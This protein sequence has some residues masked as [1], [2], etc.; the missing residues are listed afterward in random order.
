MYVYMKFG[1][2]AFLIPIHPPNYHFMYNLINKC[3]NNDIEVDI[4]LV[5]SNTTDYFFFNIYY[6]K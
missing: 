2:V 4:F 3:R 5:F 1:N 6:T